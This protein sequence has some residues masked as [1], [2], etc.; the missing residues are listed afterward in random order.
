MLVPRIETGPSGRAGPGC[1]VKPEPD[2]DAASAACAGCGR[3]IAER[4]Y[5]LAVGRTW[6]LRCLK[7]RDCEIALDTE[8]SC[9]A[10]DGGIYCRQDYYRRFSSQRCSGCGSGIPASELVMRA[11]DSVFHLRCFRCA[12]C[13]RPLTP[14]DH[15]GMRGSR[16]Y[17]RPHFESLLRDESRDDA[18]GGAASAGGGGGSVVGGS[19]AGAASSLLMQ[20]GPGGGVLGGGG[21]HEVGPGGSLGHGGG[22]GGGPPP[23]HGRGRGSA[24]RHRPR[25]RKPSAAHGAEILEYGLGLGCA[26]PDGCQDGDLGYPQSQKSKRMRTSFKHHQLRTMKSF[27]ALNHNPDAKD[28]KQLAQKTGLTKRVLQVWFQNARAKF[29]RNLLRPEEGGGRGAGMDKGCGGEGGGGPPHPSPGGGDL[30]SPPLSPALSVTTLT[31]LTNPARP[32]VTS[33]PGVV[34]SASPPPPHLLA[35]RF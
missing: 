13:E 26:D 33:V 19:V 29:R 35:R 8:L 5:L 9:Y 27:F 24:Q 34:Q 15:F 2:G 14:G 12:A 25:K 10:R 16:V 1:G 3:L 30:S 32:T 22:G 7:C 31:D 11:R 28:L 21:W 23:V 20:G 4:F 17:C 6:H 18:G